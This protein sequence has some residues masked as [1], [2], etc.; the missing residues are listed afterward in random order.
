MG[1]P[2][3]GLK[4]IDLLR[5]PGSLSVLTSVLH[6]RKPRR[7]TSSGGR[8]LSACY[9]GVGLG[10]EAHRWPQDRRCHRAGVGQ[11]PGA[12]ATVVIF[13]LAAQR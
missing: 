5:Q 10:T 9:L 12:A 2:R 7:L 11:V 13:T 8:V 1:W 3:R 4:D 6:T